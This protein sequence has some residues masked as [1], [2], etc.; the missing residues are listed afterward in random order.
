[1]TRKEII[2]FLEGLHGSIHQLHATT[3]EPNTKF[4]FEKT[5]KLHE[6][7]NQLKAENENENEK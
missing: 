6:I 1:M 7:I 4:V 2:T 3:L 5:G